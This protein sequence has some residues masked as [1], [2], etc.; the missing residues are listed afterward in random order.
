MAATAVVSLELTIHRIVERVQT[1]YEDSALSIVDYA[2]LIAAG[3]EPGGSSAGLAR[4]LS[5]V[6]PIAREL[7]TSVLVLSQLPLRF[8]DPRIERACLWW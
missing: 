1:I 7:D 3:P 4:V 6:K 5:A 2:G 8:R